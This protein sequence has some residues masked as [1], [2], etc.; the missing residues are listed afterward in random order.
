MG[1]PAGV[2]PELAARVWLKARSGRARPLR[3]LAIGDP[4]VFAAALRRLGV[5]PAL[6]VLTDPRDA[7]RAWPD[8]LPV[9]VP[10]GTAPVTPPAPGRPDPAWA[11]RVTA[12]IAHA[13]ALARCGAVR[14]VVTNP[15][16]KAVLYADGFRF[17][18]HTEYLAA[19]CTTDGQPL[20]EPVMLLV[21]GPLRVALATVHMPLRA[22]PNALTRERLLTVARAVASGLRRDFGLPHPRLAFAGLNP[23][24]GEQGSLGTEELTHI[25]PAA[26]EL[27]AEGLDITDAQPG[28]TVFHAA[29][30]G[31][32]DAVIAMYH[33][34]GLAALK[35]YDFWG[36][37]NVTLGLPVVRTSPDH[38]TGYEAARAGT[39]RTDSLE[40]ALRLAT[41]LSRQR[42]AQ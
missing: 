23:H 5:D 40:A 1:E 36:G 26:A 9:L 27:R 15:L 41:R 20:P 6:A 30:T 8:A 42:A 34:Q 7:V 10:P 21:A 13:T 35:T 31:S 33:D 32:F 38:G 39:A 3:F 28:D 29:R 19:L 22:V 12:A 2:G 25:N 11:S 16:D 24:A 17:P 4:A 14:A 18:G 37:V